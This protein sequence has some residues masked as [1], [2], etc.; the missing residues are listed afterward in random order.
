M[1]KIAITGANSAVGQNL[2]SH[3]SRGDEFAAIAGVRSETAL[4]SLP[5]A[6]NIEPMIITYEDSSKLSASLASAQV[7]VHLAGIL[8][9]ERGTDYKSANVE[10]THAVV[11]AAVKSHSEHMIFISVLGANA[12]SRNPYLKS[13]GRAEKIVTQCGI[14]STIIRTTI[15]LGPGTAGADALVR[16]VSAGRARLLAGGHYVVRPL[17]LDDLST[18]ILNTVRDMPEASSALVLGGPKSI[19][20]HDLVLKFAQL[21]GNVVKISAI[22]IWLAKFGARIAR[23]VTGGGISPAVIDVITANE[24]IEQNGDKDLVV[25]L[26]PLIETLDKII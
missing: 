26:T 1:K 16:T 17:D 11:E 8:I 7:V 3:I 21:R 2:L 23:T 9:E 19:F 24:T 5:R 15:L 12:K 10:A 18:A 6:S 20:Y 25:E 13:K 22:P 4:K 14:P